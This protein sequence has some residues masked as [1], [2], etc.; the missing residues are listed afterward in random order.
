MCVCVCV[1]YVFLCIKLFVNILLL[2][3]QLDLNNLQTY[4]TKK[5]VKFTT[6]VGI[7]VAKTDI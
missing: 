1:F 2:I 5:I 7:F 6:F 4:P 3:V